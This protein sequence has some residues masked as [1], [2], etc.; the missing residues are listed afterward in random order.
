MRSIHSVPILGAILLAAATVALAGTA[1]AGKAPPPYTFVDPGTLGGPQSY[2]NLP[3]FPVT[4]KGALIGT[5]DT[6]V[7][8][9]DFPNFNPF[10]VN[11]P[12]GFTAH[13]FSYQDG[14]MTDLGALPGN[15]SSAVFQINSKGVGV[16]MSGDGTIDPVTGWPADHAVMFED[17]QVTELGTL[18]GGDESFAISVNDRGQVAGFASNGTPDDFS[19][20]QWGSQVR[21]FVWQNGVMQ[22]I[23]TLGGPDAVMTTMNAR[24]QVMGLSYTSSTP[25]DTNGIPPVHPFIWE[26]GFMRDLGS[27]GGTWT[28]PNWMNGAGQVTGFSTLAGDESGR[29]FLWDGKHMVSIPTLGGD[30]SWANYV[31]DAGHV[32]GLAGLPGDHAYHA[33]IWANGKMTDLKPPGGM[34]CSNAFAVNNHDDVVGVADDCFGNTLAPILWHRGVPYDLNT[35]VGPTDMFMDEP[36]FIADSGEIAGHGFLESGDVHMYMLVPG[37]H[38][39]AAALDGVEPRRSASPT[40]PHAPDSAPSSGCG[41]VPAFVPATACRR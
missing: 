25:T 20:F 35:L 32:V 16:G 26:K 3:G 29:A 33:F 11:W 9:S 17:G 8:D 30:F 12:N 39:G 10:M 15:N 28:S 7:L 40:R 34:P 4:K 1:Q 23:G 13:A 6:S 2:M 27:L 24:G 21:S 19:F 5:A 18:P 31:N 36:E 22:D 41:R 37:A 38:G 14:Q